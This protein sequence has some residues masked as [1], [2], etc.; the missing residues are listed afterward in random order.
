MNTET[1]SFEGT[2]VTTESIQGENIAFGDFYQTIYSGK[3][4]LAPVHFDKNDHEY[5]SPNFTTE[6]VKQLA[7]KRIVLISEN[8]AIVRTDLARNVAAQLQQ[9]GPFSDM[10]VF[11]LLREDEEKQ[12][13]RSAITETLH[14][15]DCHEKII[16]LYDLHPEMVNYQFHNLILQTRE[17][18]CVFV[19]TACCGPEI[20]SKAGKAIVDYWFSIPTGRHY[21]ELQLQEFLVRKLRQHPPAFLE[22]TVGEDNFLLS[23]MITVS[24]A[25]STLNTF[26]Q[27]QLFLTCYSN[28]PTFPTDHKV[29]D[30]ITM[31][32][33]GH[34]QM[35]RSWF[36]QL[37]HRNK[38]LAMAAA[39]FDGMLVDQY[40]E[41]LKTITETTFWQTSEPFLTAIDYFNLS[42]LDAF[43]LLQTR[44]EEQFVIAKSQSSKMVLLELGKSEYRRHFKTAFQSFLKMTKQTYERRASNWELFGTPGKRVWIRQ[45]FTE[46]LC[47]AGIIEFGLVENHL[48]DLASTGQHFLQNICAKAM[49]QWRINGQ[50][51][52][53]F[54][55]LKAWREDDAI[56]K[57][58]ETL[59][60]RNVEQ[61]TTK[62][63]KAIDLIKSTAVLALGQA[64]YYDQPNKL[65]EEIVSSMVHF[66]QEC[67]DKPKL[68]DN[69]EKALPQFIHLHTLQLEHDLY[70]KLM[71][72]YFLRQPI[73]DGLTLALASYPDEVCAALKRWLDKCM[74][75]A[76][77]LNRRSAPTYRDNRLI[78]I[79]HML[80]LIDLSKNKIFTREALYTDFLIPLIQQENRYE[81]VD[82]VLILLAKV[83][84]QDYELAAKYANQTIGK[85]DKERRLRLIL[86][87][88][89]TYRH[90]RLEMADEDG[91]YERDGNLY[92]VW[93]KNTSRPLT[94]IERTLYKWME[95][96]DM[97]RRFATLT[98]LELAR[99]Y[100]RYEPLALR[101]REL[102]QQRQSILQ[103]QQYAQPPR[104]VVV[105]NPEIQLH[106]GLRIKIFFYFLFSSN[107]NKYLLKDTVLLFLNVSRYTFEDL[108]FIVKRWERSEQKGITSKLA[109]W[110]PKFF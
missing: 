105:T 86:L 5:L 2:S 91:T 104:P 65:H 84:S 25:V 58:M 81:V 16:L 52:L 22:E 79:L 78:I 55:T 23:P 4:H 28:L 48:L 45:S 33:Q 21:S 27:V 47:S 38:I 7:E 43:F 75:E 110:L 34:E 44:G 76:S 88:G 54:G 94:P 99:G 98:F 109:K 51:D 70:E 67:G 106:L 72:A 90:Q 18:D 57:R 62:G 32:S 40:F 66:A 59:F 49:A 41:A 36:Y 69:I 53:F 13:G 8:D 97:L 42:F 12:E 19:I 9:Q 74:E 14:S 73:I 46:T 10:R 63:A 61:S 89:H 95:Y 77:K 87:W 103:A 30:L 39:L 92:A 20:W 29:N 37:N 108:Q 1:A 96:D 50:E 100:D 71:P 6:L 11:E 17:D 102:Y 82:H 64:S 3:D 80:Y 35:V 15:E 107:Q 24:N 60:A 83:Q 101:E 56:A 31:F 68:R 26:E 85:L 93:T